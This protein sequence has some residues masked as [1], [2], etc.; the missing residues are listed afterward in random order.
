M[1]INQLISIRYKNRLT[2][3]GGYPVFETTFYDFINIDDA[4]LYLI[5]KQ[6]NCRIMNRSVRRAQPNQ[7]RRVEPLLAFIAPS[8]GGVGLLSL[9][10]N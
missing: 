1:T 5:L 2:R 7:I 6:A 10:L 9:F 3:E 8:F 4:T